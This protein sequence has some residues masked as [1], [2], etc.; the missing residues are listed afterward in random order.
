MEHDMIY[1]AV[2]KK[3]STFTEAIKEGLNMKAKFTLLTH[4]SQRYTKMPLLDEIKGNPNVGIAFDMMTVH[5]DNMKFIPSIYPALE[6][7]WWEFV[8]DLKDKSTEYKIR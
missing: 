7:C 6:K 5:P 1:D 4:F 3:H 2:I 8:E